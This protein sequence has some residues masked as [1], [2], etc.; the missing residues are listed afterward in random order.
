MSHASRGLSPATVGV[1]CRAATTSGVVRIDPAARVLLDLAEAAVG[2]AR[3]GRHADARRVVAEA[4][5]L[6]EAVTDVNALADSALALGE[7][8][9]LLRVP[10]YAKGHF[11]RALA[12]YE[13][14][15]DPWGSARARSG[16]GRAVA[17]CA[18]R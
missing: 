5:G 18:I 3:A 17:A 12:L 14:L 7:A 2:L 15:G 9:L 10:R 16:A 6:F 8:L 4:A 13:R 11:E 1:E